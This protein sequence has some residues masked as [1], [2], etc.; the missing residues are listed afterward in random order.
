MRSVTSIEPPENHEGDSKSERAYHA[1]RERIT[2]GSYAPGSRLVLD[3][4][5][6]ELAISPVPVREALRRLEAE[7][8]IVY[9]RNVGARVATIDAGQYVHSM[10]VLAYLE[11]AA[12]ALAAP[13]L[14]A[15]DVDRAREVNERLAASLAE[16]D[17]LGFTRHNQEF[18]LIL[19]GIANGACPNPHLRAL[20]EREWRRL[21]VIRRSTFSFVPVRARRSVEEHDELLGLIAGGASAERI[22]RCAR[23][24]KL[25]TMTAF[26]EHLE[27]TRRG[28]A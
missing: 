5:A 15:A 18:H 24:H 10:E 17:P 16:F 13:R 12:T 14:G 8:Y 4:I 3:R 6:R 23:D 11:G 26:L 28:G 20:I 27:R 19:C 2:D 22:E 25:G 7:G 9:E 21:D 1:I